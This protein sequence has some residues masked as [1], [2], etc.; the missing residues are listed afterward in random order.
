[1]DN[2][3]SPEDRKAL[4]ADCRKLE[5]LAR[6]AAEHIADDHIDAPGGDSA[7]LSLSLLS[8]DAKEIFEFLR[9]RYPLE[10]PVGHRIER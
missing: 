5:R 4:I 3:L 7:M 2:P 8:V 9:R 1:M 10:G 6:K